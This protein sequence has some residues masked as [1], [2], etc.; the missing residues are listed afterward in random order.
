MLSPGMNLINDDS[1]AIEFM[2]KQNGQET[3]DIVFFGSIEYALLGID[4]N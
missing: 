1:T 3:Q 4:A 2:I